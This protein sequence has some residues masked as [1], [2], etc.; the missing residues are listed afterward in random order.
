MDNFKVR[1]VDTNEVVVEGNV[2]KEPHRIGKD[3]FRIPIGTNG[4]IVDIVTKDPVAEQIHIGYRVRAKGR[5]IGRKREDGQF[6]DEMEAVQLVFE[7][8]KKIYLVGRKEI[9]VQ[10]FRVR[11]HSPEEASKLIAENESEGEELGSLEYHS[12]M[13]R[14]QWNTEEEK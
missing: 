11:A 12:T 14:S 8:P 2:A 1:G 10:N 3:V 6:T 7:P 13:D 9:H 4:T 5:I